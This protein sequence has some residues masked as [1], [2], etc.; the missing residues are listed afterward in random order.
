MREDSSVFL[1]PHGIFCT[2][3]QGRENIRKMYKLEMKFTNAS[4]H[5]KVRTTPGDGVPSTTHS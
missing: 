2:F 1:W 5:R 4:A 3:T